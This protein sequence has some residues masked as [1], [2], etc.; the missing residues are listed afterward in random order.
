MT[1]NEKV[2]LGAIEALDKIA[3]VYCL[4]RNGNTLTIKLSLDSVD[5]E[6]GR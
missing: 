1:G 3:L 5:L 4:S 2:L 6:A